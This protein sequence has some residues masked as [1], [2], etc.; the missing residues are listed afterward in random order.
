LNRWH[1]ATAAPCPCN[2]RLNPLERT[3]EAF[4]GP[5]LPAPCGDCPRMGTAPTSRRPEKTG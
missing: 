4:A 2:V 1:L 3:D 5:C